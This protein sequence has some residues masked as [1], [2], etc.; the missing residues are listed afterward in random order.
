M[1]RSEGIVDVA[2]V[3]LGVMG[4]MTAWRAATAGAS[5]VGVE[6]F[7]IGHDRGS[8]HGGS[9]IF[10]MILFEG[11]EY[12]PIARRSLSLYRELERVTGADLLQ[13]SGGLVIGPE[14]GEIIGEAVTSA[15]VAEVEYELL[16][17]DQLRARYPQH[18]V[19]DDDVAVYEKGAGTLRPEAA[20]VAAVD[21]ARAAGA[22]IITGSQ[23]DE[24]VLNDDWIG[25]AVDGRQIR[26]RRVVVSTGAWFPDQVPGVDIPMR[27]QRSCLSWF[28]PRSDR[29]A[30]GPERFPTFV[31]ESGHL[32]GWGIPDID[33]RG[34]K[35]GI[36]PSA[37]KEWLDRPEDNWRAPTAADLDPVAAFT[38]EAFPGL[39]PTAASAAACMNSK[40]PDGDFV[41]G[42]APGLPQVVLVGGFSGH[43]FKHAAGVGDIA[44]QLALDGV[45]D[46]PLDRFAPGR[47]ATAD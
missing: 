2:V 3:G 14:G 28:S 18:A 11:R 33:G 15:D 21:A 16:D 34:V 9:R 13:V 26:A 44:S 41:I 46:I 5:V 20:V 42:L 6:R 8:S 35:V 39:V 37:S 17:T 30:Y 31:R 4:A 22:E 32:N 7:E 27:V 47:F 40:T 43:G 36:G 23:V 10:R 29:A 45:S 12:V 25:I 1:S 19:F 24:V 38:A